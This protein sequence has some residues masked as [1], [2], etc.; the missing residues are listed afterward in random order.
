[1]HKGN[2]MNTRHFLATTLVILCVAL[3]QAA[4]ADTVL[5]SEAGFIQGQQ[6]FVQSFDITSKGQLTIT[7]TDVP[8]LDTIKDLNCFVSTSSGVLGGVMGG[9]GTETINVTPGMVYA[10]WFGDA[11]GT[12]GL[13]VYGMKITFQPGTVAAVSLPGSLV[14]LLSGLAALFTWRRKRVGIEAPMADSALTI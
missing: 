14:L 13:G 11:A 8:W 9:A 10:H 6:S 5:Y 4:R 1:M 12:Y 2:D 7:L 3:G